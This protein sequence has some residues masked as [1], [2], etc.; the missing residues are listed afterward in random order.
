[1]LNAITTFLEKNN[2]NHL[3]DNQKILVSQGTPEI[4]DL[5]G[6]NMIQKTGTEI[7]NVIVTET[8]TTKK[9]E[10]IERGRIENMVTLVKKEIDTEIELSLIHI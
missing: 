4:P 1:M 8:D 6:M 5:Q 9:N 2:T 3:N 7:E 10:N